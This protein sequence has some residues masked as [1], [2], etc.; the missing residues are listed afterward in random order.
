MKR[1]IPLSIVVV[2]AIL[3]SGCRTPQPPELCRIFDL[4]ANYGDHM[5]LQRDKEIRISGSGE[6]GKL[7]QVRLGED[8]AIWTVVEDDGRWTAILQPMPAGGPYTLTVSGDFH[9]RGLELTDIMV[10]E[11]WICSGQSNMEMPIAYTNPFWGDEN[12]KTLLAEADQYPLIRIFNESPLK[13]VSPREELLQPRAKWELATA[14]TLPNFSSVAYNFGRQ[15]SKD[16]PGIAI[17]L[18]SVN[19]GGTRIQPWI[20]KAGY[21][22]AERVRELM[23]LNSALAPNEELEAK[24]REAKEKFQA[25]QRIWS[26]KMSNF[27]AEEAAAA[28]EWKNA[29]YDDSAWPVLATAKN[30]FPESLEGIAWLRKT[31]IVPQQWLGHDLVLNLGTVDDCDWTYVNGQLVGQTLTDTMEYWKAPRQYK[32]PANLIKDTTITIAVRF[33]DLCGDGGITSEE[34]DMTIRWADNL[35]VGMNIHRD[36]K[37]QL[38]STFEVGDLGGQ[39]IFSAGIMPVDNQQLPTTLYNSMISPWT[40]YPIRGAIWYQGCSNANEPEN[41]FELQQVLVNDWRRAWN[42]PDMPFI[43]CQLSGFG[44]H[45]PEDRGDENA[46]RNDPPGKGLYAPIRDAQWRAIRK[47]HN[48]GMAVTYDVGDQYDIH[49]HDKGTVGYRL[50]KEAE[51]ICYG[52]DGITSGPEFQT[53]A[54]EGDKVIVTFTNVGGGLVAKGNNDGK[55]GACA[56]AGADGNL[57]T[58]DAVIVGDTLVISS[59]AVPEPVEVRYG[60]ISYSEDINLYNAEDYPALPFR[61][62]KQ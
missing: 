9:M 44:S 33:A 36:W 6:P 51:R 16:M 55:V 42:D 59:P 49:P 28:A 56:I 38:E 35:M 25:E 13:R 43:I 45:R 54:F 41:Y 39:P 19:W 46:W 62:V 4:D 34:K 12:H 11:V 8:N 21:E 26:D 5:V 2:I 18:I 47:Q 10:G 57:V 22:A 37:F 17:G 61:A 24:F 50:A 58:A 40:K 52:Y 53:A 32:V 14:E 1:I 20:S 23:E 15:L 27:K 29:D 7:L 48:T 31:I 3:I 30:A 60:W